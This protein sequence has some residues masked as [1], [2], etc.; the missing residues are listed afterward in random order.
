[1]VAGRGARPVLHLVIAAEDVAMHLTRFLTETVEPGRA[2]PLAV[3][4][5]AHRKADSLDKRLR[6]VGGRC[7]GSPR[8]GRRSSVAILASDKR[9]PEIEK[10]TVTVKTGDPTGGFNVS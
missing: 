7:Q 4:R 1:M 5:G 2:A 3:A 8:C 9:P 6:N 10:L